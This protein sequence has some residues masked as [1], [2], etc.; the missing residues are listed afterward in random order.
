MKKTTKF[1]STFAPEEKL[2]PKEKSTWKKPR[3][4]GS[5]QNP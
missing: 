3:L 5:V 2:I 4:K 1:E